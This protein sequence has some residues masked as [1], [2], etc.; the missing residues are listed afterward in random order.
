MNYFNRKGVSKEMELVG[1]G[2]SG[3]VSEVLLAKI[4]YWVNFFFLGEV[5]VISLLF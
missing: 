2:F 1:K 5:I 4:K 3:E